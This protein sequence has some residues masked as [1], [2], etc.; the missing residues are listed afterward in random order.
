MCCFAWNIWRNSVL[1]QICCC[2]TEGLNGRP[3][4]ISR[5][6]RGLGAHPEKHWF[7]TAPCA[8]RD[9]AP[10]SNSIQFS[11]PV[12]TW[13]LPFRNKITVLLVRIRSRVA[14]GYYRQPSVFATDGSVVVV[15]KRIWLYP[16]RKKNTFY[17]HCTHAYIKKKSF[18]KQYL[19]LQ[20][21]L[22]SD[23]FCSFYSILFH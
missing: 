14:I 16:T 21:A 7:R 13:L 20:H 9:L 11:F 15:F 18:I 1:T 5:I 6:L 22:H 12:N 3:G 8:M 4:R 17:I 23:I 2:K 19:E 10:T